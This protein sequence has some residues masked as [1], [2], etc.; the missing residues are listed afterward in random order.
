MKIFNILCFSCT[1]GDIFTAI[2][3]SVLIS[4]ASG[5]D[6]LVFL[7]RKYLSL[8]SKKSESQVTV[9]SIADCFRTNHIVLRKRT[10]FKYQVLNQFKSTDACVGQY[11][12]NCH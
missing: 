10:H 11:F 2:Q 7:F 1:I 3:Y 6:C 12:G 5:I 8:A 4:D 9:P